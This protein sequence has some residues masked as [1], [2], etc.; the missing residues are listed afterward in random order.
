IPAVRS[1][2][3]GLAILMALLVPLAA[4]TISVRY[5]TG[6]SA[7]TSRQATERP[8]VEPAQD[9]TLPGTWDIQPTNQPRIVQVHLREGHSSY[10]TTI[11][12]DRTNGF[13][14]AQY[15]TADGPVRFSLGRDAGTFIFEG[16]VRRGIGAGTYTFAPSATFPAELA[17]R[18]LGQPS[19]GEQRLLAR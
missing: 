1:H 15:Q 7:A 5:V 9:P 14:V 8:V 6:K 3:V 10:S 17:K 4:G 2:L 13:P 19:P 16:I 12:I 11:D 18:G